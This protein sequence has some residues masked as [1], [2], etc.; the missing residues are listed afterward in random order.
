M[1]NNSKI[2]NKLLE[3]IFNKSLHPLI[4]LNSKSEITFFNEKA[5][6]WA[7]LYSNT[8]LIENKSIRDYIQNDDIIE[9]NDEIYSV[10]NNSDDTI[11]PIVSIML[12]ME[13]NERWYEFSIS[14]IFTSENENY[15]LVTIEDI[16][17]R[18]KTIDDLAERERRFKSL[19]QNSSDII[20]ILSEEGKF[21]YVSDSV[22]KYLEYGVDDFMGRRIQIFI[23]PQDQEKFNVF[24]LSILKNEKKRYYNEFQLLD[25]HGHHLYFAVSANNQIDNPAIKGIIINARDITDKKYADEMM[26]R[27]SRQNEIILETANEG[28]FGLNAKGLITLINPYGAKILGFKEEEIL[29]IHFSSLLPVSLKDEKIFLAEEINHR[30]DLSFTKKDASF[31]AVEFFS[32]PI[33]NNAKI[34]GSVVTFNDITERKKAEEELKQAKISADEANKAKSDFL[35]QMSHEIR[36]P[37]NSILGFLELLYLTDLNSEQQDFVK[38]V[39]ESAIHLL[40]IINDILDFSKIEKG[41]IDLELIPFDP[42]KFFIN[43]FRM[44]EAN[45]A[46]KNIH[47]KMSI[48]EQMCISIG[49]PF[50]LKQVLTNLIGNA[51][52]FTPPDGSIDVTIQKKADYSGSCDIFFEV[53]DTGIGIPIERQNAVFEAFTQSS[54]STTRKFGGTGLGLTISNQLIKIMGSSIVLQSEQG[55]GSSFSFLL[56]L[57]KAD[58]NQQKLCKDQSEEIQL[59]TTDMDQFSMKVLVA[60]DVENNRKVINLMLNKFGITPEFA[61]N[62]KTAFEIFKSRKFDIIFMDGNMPVC[63]GF[64]AT[65]LIRAYEKENQLE[66]TPIIALT[67]KAIKGDKENFLN[68]GMDDYL[69]KPINLK[70]ILLA[71]KKHAPYKQTTVIAEQKTESGTTNQDIEGLIDFTRL[72]EQMG[73]DRETVK[74]LLKD[75]IKDIDSYINQLESA[76]KSGNFKEM[77]FASHKLKGI[78]STYLIKN[79]SVPSAEI[80]EMSAKN[81]PADYYMLFEEIKKNSVILKN[82]V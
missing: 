30:N 37:M 27:M 56:K 17:G 16:S 79:I 32:S 6:K 67:A 64:Q 45:A 73:L 25:K 24:L 70:T 50:R 22:K 41:K 77:E 80:E 46:E 2:N 75:F 14:K 62:G 29:G 52:K 38:T 60:E 33:Y 42:A 78:A 48:D 7:L 5:S 35:A 44:F 28:I 4:I 65:G 55:K 81:Q 36:T 47:F 9:L 26:N 54:S 72:E 20:A 13:G 76:V 15:V 69:T 71:L 53:K 49:D 82:S 3:Q 63:D 1:E 34:S 19:V 40:G 66:H 8:P 43:T 18:K 39:S 31:V 23:A 74:M 68:A 58:E 10:S 21:R 12:D 57:P 59:K 11:I 61:E 51:I